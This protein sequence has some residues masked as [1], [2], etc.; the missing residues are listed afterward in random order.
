LH[1]NPELSLQETNTALF[2]A[3]KMRSYGYD[4]TEAVGG[5]GLVAT[6]QNGDGPCLMLRTDM[7]ALP[8]KEATGL[9]YASQ[10]RGV[11]EN[12]EVADVMHACGHD[13]HMT[14]WLGAARWMAEHKDH[15]S[16]T[17]CWIGQPAEELGAGARA[18][19]DDGLYSRFP[20]PDHCLALHVAGDLEAGKVGICPGYAMANVDSVDILVRGKGGHGAAPHLAIDPIVIS[21]RIVL[22][23]Q[24]IVSREVDPLDSAVVTV[25]VIQAGTK[26]NVIPDTALLQLTV[27]TYS[28]E[29]RTHVL[30]SIERLART[31]AAGAGVPEATLPTI[32]VK[33]EFT[34]SVYNDPRLSERLRAVFV[35]TLGETNVALRKPEMIGEDFA[36]YGRTTDKI[37]ICMFRVGT[38]R[39]ADGQPKFQSLHSPNFAPE[40][41]LTLRTAVGALVAAALELVP[42]PPS[43][44]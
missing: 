21:S 31:T 25:G 35:R 23:L 29:V 42:V 12:G 5:T 36:R 34:P 28:E 41:L 22:A 1:A 19:L 32:T 26:R 8:L 37:P 15:W 13:V 17:I 20:K 18:M 14:A 39:V 30:A 4:V 9:T 16:G 33:D 43:Q 27:R 10:A 3:D 7:D 40:E 2:L 38:A 24:T 6:L 44:N 11:T